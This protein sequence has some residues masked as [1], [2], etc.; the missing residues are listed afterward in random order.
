M[1]IHETNEEEIDEIKGSSNELTDEQ[2]AEIEELEKE[3]EGIEVHNDKLLQRLRSLIHDEYYENVLHRMKNDPI[4]W[5]EDFGYIDRNGNLEKY[6][7]NIVSIDEHQ[8][9]E[10]L[11]DEMG[12]GQLGHYDGDYNTV[13]VE[14]ETYY[15]IR[16]E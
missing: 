4:S 16:T 7:L 12:I 2:E 10:D 9:K 1:A 6:A 15:I 14:N 8:L 13:D 5:L 11:V 3:N